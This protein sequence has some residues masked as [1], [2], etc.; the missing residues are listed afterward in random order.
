MDG[1]GLLFLGVLF[2]E[3]LGAEKNTSLICSFFFFFGVARMTD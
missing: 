1:L 2:V 3:L